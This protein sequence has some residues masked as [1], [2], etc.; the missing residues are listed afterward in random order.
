MAAPYSYGFFLENGT[1]VVHGEGAEHRQAF[2]IDSNIPGELQIFSP[3]HQSEPRTPCFCGPQGIFPFTTENRMPRHVHMSPNPSGNG[4][5][6]VVEKIMVMEGIALAELGGQIYVIPPNTM[7]VIGPGVPHAWV[8]CPPGLDLQALG[9]A[10]RPLVSHG[11]FVAVFEYE[12]P[13]AF[14][15]TAQVETLKEESDYVRCNDL[16]SIRF[17][18]MS[19]EE[20]RTTA[21]F[22]WGRKATKLE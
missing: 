16:E 12:Q 13:T 6:Y 17:P 22:V 8:A 4:K 21:L 9:V 18:E 11:K 10:D 14:F 15:P 20:I 3:G 1:Q 7:V 5:R 19:L 2:P